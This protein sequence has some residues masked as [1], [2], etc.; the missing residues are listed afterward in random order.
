MRWLIFLLLIFTPGVFLQAQVQEQIC[1]FDTPHATRFY[2]RHPTVQ[3]KPTSDTPFWFYSTFSEQGMD[4]NVLLSGLATLD[5]EPNLRSYL[6]IRNGRIV[7]EQYY[8]GAT[9]T[10]SNNVHSVNKSII[11]ALVGIALNQGFIRSVDQP[12][13]DFLPEDMTLPDDKRNLTLRHLLTMSTGL[14]WREGSSEFF[15]TRSDNWLQTIL[16]IAPIEL[17]GERFN[18]STGMSHVMSM[19]L[20][21]ATGMST[22]DFAEQYLFEPLGISVEYW[23]SDPQGYF[24][25]GYNFHITPREL[26]KFGLLYLNRGAWDGRLLVT[27]TWVAESTRAQIDIGN[28]YAGYGF[29]WWLNRIRGYD[30]YSAVGYAGQ[31]LHIIPDLNMIIVSTSNSRRRPQ[32]GEEPAAYQFI[33][34]FVIPSVVE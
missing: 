15:V 6:I 11:S 20:T 21:E 3:D 2:Q 24:S 23:G 14:G 5:N 32:P 22:C 27:P 8:N 29:Y 18:Y 25:G 30:M 10:D 4:G 1:V 28:N 34:D 26:A 7:F 12:I 16:N 19:I 31:Y 9:L 33:A 13:S 17:P